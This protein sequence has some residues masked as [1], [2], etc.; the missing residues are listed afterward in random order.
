MKL[1]GLM[2]LR[3]VVAIILMLVSSVWAFS[4][5]HSIQSEVQ[6]AERRLEILTPCDE[7]QRALPIVSES[8][9]QID[10][11]RDEASIRLR[12]Y[13]E[14]K[15]LGKLYLPAL[16]FLPSTLFWIAGS[17]VGWIYRGFKQSKE[18]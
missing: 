2:R 9:T 17:V 6:L 4:H 13:S 18:T 7:E 1:N 11:N 12:V 16:A 10:S 5:F 3:I 15:E 8:C 14:A